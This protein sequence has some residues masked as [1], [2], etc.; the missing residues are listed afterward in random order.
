MSI[1]ELMR[2]INPITIIKISLII[3]LITE[4]ALLFLNSIIDGNKKYFGYLIFFLSILFTVFCDKDLFFQSFKNNKKLILLKNVYLFLLICISIY[5][6]II[7]YQNYFSF[8][9]SYTIFLFILTIIVTI[10]FH[11]LLVIILKNF[12]RTK[13][14]GK[15]KDGDD[16]INEELIEEEIRKAMANE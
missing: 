6:P 5:Y 8:K 16:D 10:I 1:N 15:E 7:F 11:F 9:E 4:I 2:K 13:T 3:S 12:I 14:R